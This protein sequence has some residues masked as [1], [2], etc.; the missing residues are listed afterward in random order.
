MED[1][2]EQTKTVISHGH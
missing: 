1:F 2:F